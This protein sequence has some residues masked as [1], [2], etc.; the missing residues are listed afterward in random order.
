MASFFSKHL[1]VSYGF[2]LQ[3]TLFELYIHLLNYKFIWVS[4]SVVQV[5]SKGRK[6]NV[7]AWLIS[8]TRLPHLFS[9]QSKI[10]FDHHVIRG[11]YR[12]FR[13]VSIT[14]VTKVFVYKLCFELFFKVHKGQSIS[15]RFLLSSI[16][17]K[18]RTKTVWF[19]PKNDFRSVFWGNR[20]HQKAISKLTDL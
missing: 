2:S 16:S 13:P 4:L 19:P 17:S 15:K 9:C 8:N 1:K 5:H 6:I 18:K 20:R 10:I 12:E 7:M 14:L 11:R 3:V